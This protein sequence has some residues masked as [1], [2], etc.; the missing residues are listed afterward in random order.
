[1]F[2]LYSWGGAFGLPSIDPDCVQVETYLAL[3]GADWKV[4][5]DSNPAVSPT[6]ELPLLCHEEER[7]VGADKII[8]YLVQQGY[9]LNRGLDKR[10]RATCSAYT[11]LL[12]GNVRDAQLYAWYAEGENFV[13][14]VRPTYAK[15]LPLSS[16]Y[17]EPVRLRNRARAR[18][19]RYGVMLD[20]ADVRDKKSEPSSPIAPHKHH[21]PMHKSEEE[22]VRARSIMQ[23]LEPEAYRI[24]KESYA[25]L[26]AKL[27]ESAFFFGSKPT[28]L[29]VIAYGHLSLHIYPTLPRDDLSNQI[30]KRHS[31]L[32]GLCERMREQISRSGKPP[33]PPL[34]EEDECCRWQIRTLPASLWRSVSS[35]Y[36][37]PRSYLWHTFSRSATPK[38]SKKN[39]KEK[40]PAE[41]AFER[42]RWASVAGGVLA[43]ITYMVANGMIRVD[44]G[45]RDGHDESD[46]QDRGGPWMDADDEDD[47]ESL[48]D[49]DYYDE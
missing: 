35:F 31:N 44:M 32:V 39:Q 21:G 24:A 27:G 30:S 4:Y 29:D 2:V 13:Q 18:L 28:T 5:R 14:S 10:E 25:A 1:M 19:E 11:S 23:E 42:K 22:K 48:I 20:D 17:F 49:D 7:I 47:E 6:G 3:S 46:E 26:S 16:R 40:T 9:D 33:R 34:D 36:A 41:I 38:P 43:V 37:A 12:E 15:L 8:R 45:D